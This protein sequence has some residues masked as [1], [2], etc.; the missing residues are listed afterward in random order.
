MIEVAWKVYFVVN[1][2]MWAN[3]QRADQSR[4]LRANGACRAC[5]PFYCYAPGGTAQTRNKSRR[6]LVCLFEI[7]SACQPPEMYVKF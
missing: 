7:L 4:E 6:H 2:G 3:R 5:S 1:F